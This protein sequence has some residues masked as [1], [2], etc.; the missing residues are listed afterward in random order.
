MSKL[1]QKERTFVIIKPDGIQR[2]LIGDII[3]RIEYSGLKLIG[4]KMLVCPEDKLYVHY[5]KD[6]AWYSSKGQKVVDNIISNGGKPEK[7]AI[8]YGKDIVR[9]LVSY[10][11]SSP[12]VAMV[13]EGNEAV[14]VVRKI[15]G[16]TEPTTSDVGTIRGDYTIDSYAIANF[17]NRAVRNLIHSSELPEEADREIDIWFNSNEMIDYTHVSE[18]ILY[19]E[20]FK[21]LNE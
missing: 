15:V 11:Q 12:V 7:E 14:G 2:G 1:P 13:W 16:T 19:G 3:K 9:A 17:E 5:N 10:M 21:G 4:L 18:M 20:D 8:E 6:D